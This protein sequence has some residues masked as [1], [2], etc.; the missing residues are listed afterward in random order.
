MVCFT[1]NLSF[2]NLNLFDV[3]IVLKGK[4]DL[5]IVS[6][7]LKQFLVFEVADGKDL[8]FLILNLFLEIHIIICRVHQSYS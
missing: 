7:K 8:V 2:E 4:D 6:L 3:L 1:A 5:K